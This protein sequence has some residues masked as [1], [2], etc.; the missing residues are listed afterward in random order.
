MDE[1]IAD[2]MKMDEAIESFVERYA[3]SFVKWEVIQFYH[4][5]PD[6][7]YRLDELVKGLNR[8][9][10]SLK[11]EM[12]ELEE[13]MFLKEKKVGKTPAYQYE[14]GDSQAGKELK[15]TVDQFIAICQE[16]EGRLRVVYK[17]LKDGKPICE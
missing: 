15:N 16:R 12:Q 6:T 7:W 14:P 17:L 5:H 3:N 8:S 9:L 13:S 11:N 4:D 2:I 1:N 10:K